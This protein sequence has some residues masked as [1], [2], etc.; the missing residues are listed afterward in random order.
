MTQLG[1]FEGTTTKEYL[2][3]VSDIFNKRPPKPKYPC[4]W[5]GETVLYFLRAITGNDLL[6][7]KLLALKVSMLSAS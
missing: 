7:Q 5:D 2:P 1:T 3:N 6:S 4:T